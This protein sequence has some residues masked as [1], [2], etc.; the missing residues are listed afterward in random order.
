MSNLPPKVRKLYVDYNSSYNHSY[1]LDMF[2][3]IP[4]HNKQVTKQTYATTH[5]IYMFLGIKDMFVSNVAA[6]EAHP[7]RAR[8]LGRSATS[9]LL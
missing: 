9:S 1:L 8:I 7:D 6:M 4:S 2:S 3:Q 5:H